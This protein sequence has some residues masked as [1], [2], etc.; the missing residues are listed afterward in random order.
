MSKLQMAGIQVEIISRE[1]DDLQVFAHVYI[2]P[3]VLAADG[4]LLTNPTI[5]PVEDAVNHY[6]SALQFDGVFSITELQDKMQM[7]PGVVNPV[8]D[9]CFSKYGSQSYTQIVDFVTP[10]AGH[11]AIDPLFPLSTTIT[12]I[13]A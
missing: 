12:Y 8:I 2:D 3:L 9:N 4:S 5:F 6:I 7:V 1:A 10:N 13:N 11:L